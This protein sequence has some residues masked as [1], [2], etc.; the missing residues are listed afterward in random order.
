MDHKCWCSVSSQCMNEP[1]SG[2]KNEFIPP[3]RQ[4]NLSESKKTGKEAK[5]EDVKQKSERDT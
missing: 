1:A 3:P 4:L 5:E 2:M